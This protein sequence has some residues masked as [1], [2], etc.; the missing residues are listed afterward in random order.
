MTLIEIFTDYVVNRKSLKYYI[1]KRKT[2]NERGEFNDEQLLQAQENLDKL[3]LED[4]ETLEEMYGV[5]GEI[6]RLDRGH[7]VEYPI[8]FIR[9][10]LSISKKSKTPQAALENYKEI[11]THKYQDA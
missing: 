1:E 2:L 4:S 10:I 6:I 7:F 3:I 9:E 11:L 5:L 8:D